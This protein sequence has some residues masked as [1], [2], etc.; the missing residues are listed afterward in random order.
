MI[1]GSVTENRIHLLFVRWTYWRSLYSC[2]NSRG[3]EETAVSGLIFPEL[4]PK[5][6]SKL[7]CQK[8]C[9]SFFDWQGSYIEHCNA[10]DS[11]SDS[12]SSHMLNRCLSSVR[13]FPTK[14]WLQMQFSKVCWICSRLYLKFYVQTGEKE[15]YSYCVIEGS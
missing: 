7:S 13:P 14:I 12:C 10:T 8:Y 6:H 2:G 11:Y 9:I 3:T 1:Q 15:I 5:Y 4:L